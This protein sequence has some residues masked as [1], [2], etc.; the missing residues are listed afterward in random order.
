MSIERK[1]YLSG[2]KWEPIVGYARAVRIGN[3]IYVS[4]STATDESGEIVGIGDPYIQAKRCIHN[5]ELAL[6]ALGGD[7]QNVVRTRIYVTDIER[8]WHEIGRAHRE[9]FRDIEPATTMVEVP[10]LIDPRMLVEIEAEA[11]SEI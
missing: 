2:S 10:R 9:Y 4:G 8:H 6:K 11:C 3:A 5:I 1:N 7:L